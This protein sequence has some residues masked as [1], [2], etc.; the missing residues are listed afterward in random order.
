MRKELEVKLSTLRDTGYVELCASSSP[1][2]SALVLVRKKGS[3]L[4]VC[5]DYCGVN[6]GITLDKYPIPP[7]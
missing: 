2:S 1:Y 5:A 6:K 7:D 3:G 4:Q